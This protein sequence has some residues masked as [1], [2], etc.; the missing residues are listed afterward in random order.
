MT[1][2]AAASESP[3][4]SEALHRL[5]FSTI[6]AATNIAFAFLAIGSFLFF[7][8]FFKGRY[9]PRLLSGFGMLASVLL[10]A[11]AFALVLV[12]DRLAGLEMMAMLP[13]GVAEVTT[14]LWLLLAGV[15]LKHARAQK[16]AEPAG[17]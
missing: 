16:G 8:L 10:G 7:Y 11:L 13:L 15:S 12:P 4:G 3:A 9:L 17:G 2:Y 6:D 14:G 1:N 5:I